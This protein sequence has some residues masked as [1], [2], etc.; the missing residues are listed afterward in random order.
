VR[1]LFHRCSR[2]CHPQFKA[3][4]KVFC[5]SNTYIAQTPERQGTYGEYCHLKDEW[6]SL[7]PTSMTLTDAAAVPLV[8]LT[9]VQALDKAETKPGQRILITGGSGGVGH[10]AI[11][12]AKTDYKLHVTTVASK[13]HHA[14]LK[15]LGA[16]EVVDY[17]AGVEQCLDPFTDNKFDAIVD[18]IGGEML[19]TATAKCLKEGGIVSEIMN[20]GSQASKVVGAGGSG[21]RFATTLIQPSGEQ[22]QHLAQLIDAGKLKIQIAKTLPLE[23]AGAAQTEV[24]DGHAGGKVVLTI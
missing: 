7:A 9:A 19:D 23:Q 18:V 2:A 24:A 17:S 10:I 8:A 4:D 1:K 3:G 12:L 22:L 13:K 20:R 21:K 5:C 14:W 6:V 15:S 16:D 11:Q